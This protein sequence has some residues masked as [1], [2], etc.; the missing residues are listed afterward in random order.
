MTS[1]ERGKALSEQAIVLLGIPSDVNSSF[2]RG[3]ALAPDRIR[4]ALHSEASN[5]WSET[6]HE[7]SGANG[8]RDAGNLKDVE[9]KAGFEKITGAIQDLL[10]RNARVIALGG[11]H[12][13]TFPVVRGYARRFSHLNLLHLD[14][15]P[16]LYDSYGGNRFSHACPMARIME[17][18]LVARLIQV[19]VR[20]FNAHQREQ[21]AHFGVETVEM[22]YLDKNPAFSFNGPVYLSLDMDVL[23]PAFAPGV[24]HPEPGG[25]SPRDV[26]TLIQTLDAPLVGADIVEYNPKRDPTG[27][28]AGVAAKL[29]KEIA[30]KMLDKK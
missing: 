16:D 6:G 3:A 20:T 27:L 18:G 28:S 14:A 10:A 2:A 22:R 15:H 26:I 4:E 12:A 8:V 25:M 23:D 29:L 17:A 13:V 7:I 30:G 19:G 21:A 1:F 5:L 9:G 24:S 11:D